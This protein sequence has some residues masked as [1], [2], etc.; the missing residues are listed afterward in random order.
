MFGTCR[1]VY[2]WALRLR[3]DS[4]AEG[5]S[6]SY[7]DTS[8]KLTNLKKSEG[9]G[10]MYEVSCVPPQQALRHLQTAFTNF[11]EKRSKYPKFKKKRGPQSAEYSRSAFKWCS[12]NRNLTVSGL[13][14][15][16]IKWSRKFSSKPSTVTIT[17]DTA[18]RYF[19]TLVL[20]ETVSPLPKTG[21][22]IG[23]DLGINRLATLSS[24]EKIPNPQY[25]RRL[26]KRLARAQRIL[27]K[28]KR[29][30]KRWE[31]QR[32]KVARV[33]A[34]IADCRQDHLHKVTTDLVRRFDA[35]AVED[36]SPRNMVRNRN[37]AKSLSDVSFGAFRR[38]LEYKCRWY[39]KE[40][41]VCD[42]FFPSSK[43]C[44]S[45][46]HIVETLPLNIRSWVCPECRAHHDRD[47][48][49]AINILGAGRA[50]T[51]RG[52]TVRRGRGSPRQR[53]SRRNANQPVGQTNHLSSG[54]PSL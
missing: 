52:E 42:R 30:S 6:L 35:I 19:A 27:S 50:L 28:R 47:H 44:S 16:K 11:F 40:L 37:L 15:L 36:L 29:G 5:V 10:W 46:G 18:G 9:F 34:K 39:D 26:E 51:A 38:M 2:N 32:L 8:S 22:R 20:D 48:N 13:G 54:I 17:K 14:R 43:R 24:G 49:A 23:I 7:A 4:Y 45:C 12:V 53:S 33:Q 41:L 25:T 3:T 21:Q 1:F 31:R